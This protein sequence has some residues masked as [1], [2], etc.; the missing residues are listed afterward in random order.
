[1]IG[2][3]A[4]RVVLP[5]F[6]L[7][8]GA[9]AT[10]ALGRALRWRDPGYIGGIAAFFALAALIAFISAVPGV[11]GGGAVPTAVLGTSGITLAL[12]PLAL[13]IGCAATSILLAACL[14]SARCFG[15]ETGTEK[16][17][18]LLL[19]MAAGV[20][21]IGLAQDIF[22]MYVFFELMSVASFPLVAYH[23]GAWDP[24]K[25]ATKYA[26]MS[27]AGSVT[28]LFGIS[29]V[30][31]SAGTLEI[32]R[33]GTALSSVSPPPAQGI[34]LISGGLIVAGFGV[35][36]AIVPLHTWLPDA[37]S[38]APS[39]VSAM[40]SG[41]V[42][43][44]GLI[45]MIKAMAPLSGAGGSFP[46]GLTLAL[47]AALTMCMGNL[48]ALK[49]RDLKKMLACS[50]IAHMGYILL[51]FSFG[52]GL[53]G[54]GTELGY[55]GGLYHILGH[56]FMKGGAF[57]C[58]G[59]FIYALRSKD[60]DEMEGIGR[61]VPALGIPFVLCMLALN[62]MPPMT[63]FV[64][65]LFICRAGIASGVAGMLLVFVMLAN[66]V[67][68]FGYY[69]PAINTIVFSEGSGRRAEGMRPV[70][71]LIQL[72]IAMTAVVVVILGIAPQAGLALVSPAAAYIAS[73]FG[74]V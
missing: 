6:L 41:I 49:Q 32:S 31:M 56:V 10:Y 34:I 30:F 27:A 60:I 15:Q 20:I 68:S 43:Q 11:L 40:L 19:L 46:L 26:V 55:T 63:G 33:I 50:S 13:L 14:Y 59:A 3:E 53:Y 9:L 44:A 64:S 72:V 74:P 73:L 47:F 42:I 67:I 28:A 8:S 22:N 21:G 18:A 71:L 66:I 38:F 1:M 54:T 7:L 12:D 69:L 70:P 61:A 17:Y 2:I 62:G 24:V 16:Y 5:E 37:H 39:G 25:A 36:A 51:G 57:L 45:A 29:L 65:E 4:F 48:I 35:K 52:I 23:S 58:A